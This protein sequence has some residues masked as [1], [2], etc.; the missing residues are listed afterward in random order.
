MNSLD[1]DPG[2][3]SRRA[4]ADPAGQSPRM[5]AAAARASALRFTHMYRRRRQKSRTAR[6]MT[7]G[8]APVAEPAVRG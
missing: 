8:L 1:V 3:E 2:G 6:R 5:R 4:R 7:Y